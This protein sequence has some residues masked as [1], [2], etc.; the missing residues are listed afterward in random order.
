MPRKKQTK[1]KI[2]PQATSHKPQ[3]SSL[4]RLRHIVARHIAS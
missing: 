4:K 3:A 2:K 1:K